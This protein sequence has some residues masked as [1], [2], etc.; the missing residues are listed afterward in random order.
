MHPQELSHSRQQLPVAA[1]R[2]EISNTL[3]R[4]ERGHATSPETRS[5]GPLGLRGQ[6]R[7]DGAGIQSRAHGEGASRATVSI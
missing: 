1:F 7:M 3:R 2:S 6:R 5:S 4:R